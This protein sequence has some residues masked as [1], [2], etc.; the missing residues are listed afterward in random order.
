[1][2]AS[3]ICEQ[4]GGPRNHPPGSSACKRIKA[5]T[6]AVEDRVVVAEISKTYIDGSSPS[7]LS[8]SQLFERAIAYNIGRG[9]RLD[10]WKLD[11]LFE[12]QEGFPQLQE[13]II[14]VFIKDGPSIAETT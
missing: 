8:L 5:M 14:A 12:R 10:S 9:Y 1:M 2:T 13:T 3:L 7:D 4:C 11:R 6:E